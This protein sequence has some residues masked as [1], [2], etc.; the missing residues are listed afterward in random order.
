VPGESFYPIF[1]FLSDTTG[2]VEKN[3]V[4]RDLA[5]QVEK[6]LKRKEDEG[7]CNRIRS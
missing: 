3:A 1:Y 7:G 5:E 2:R 6:K 4:E